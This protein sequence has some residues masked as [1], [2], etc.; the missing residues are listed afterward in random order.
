MQYSTANC[1]RIQWNVGTM[2][3]T[4]YIDRTQYNA[5]Q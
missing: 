5:V 1:N 4:V 2:L 3:D